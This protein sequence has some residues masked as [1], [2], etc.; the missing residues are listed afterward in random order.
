M[1]SSLLC[2]D[3]LD[4]LFSITFSIFGYLGHYN[5]WC[6]GTVILNYIWCTMYHWTIKLKLHC[7]GNT[8]SLSRERCAVSMA[9]RAS[10]AKFNILCIET[11]FLLPYNFC[12]HCIPCYREKR[13]HQIDKY[14]PYSAMY[15]IRCL[16]VGPDESR[17]HIL[18][19][20]REVYL[21]WFYAYAHPLLYSYQCENIAMYSLS[22]SNAPYPFFTSF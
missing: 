3:R 21:S 6:H 2:P 10:W 16:G 1:K 18:L 17:G 15:A 7:E 5:F 13:C 20:H 8:S 19:S 12:F 9:S 14:L 22:P 4:S 11:L